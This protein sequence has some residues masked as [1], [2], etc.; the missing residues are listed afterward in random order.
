MARMPLP[1]WE[2]H[3]EPPAVSGYDTHKRA[4]VSRRE[5][6][7]SYVRD[8]LGTMAACTLSGS[9]YPCLFVAHVGAAG[10]GSNPRHG[11]RMVF[12][13]RLLG[14]TWLP[15]APAAWCPCS[16]SL[17]SI[18]PWRPSQET[19]YNRP[20]SPQRRTPCLL[21]RAQSPSLFLLVQGA[22]GSDSPSR[23]GLSDLLHDRFC[24]ITITK[25]CGVASS[26]WH[27]GL[28]GASHCN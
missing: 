9:G 14:S 6:C 1:G 10:R 20:E 12:N 13:R 22:I 8:T 25:P 11:K 16:V 5:F 15:R 21:S 7:I 24:A 17:F 4:R 27:P 26:L 19:S 2:R 23:P 3:A 18:G 28:S